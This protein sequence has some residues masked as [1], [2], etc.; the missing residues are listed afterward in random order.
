MATSDR[1]G[2]ATN[3]QPGGTY[4]LLLVKFKG[5]FPEGEISFGLYD[6]PM[7]ITGIQKVAQVFMKL[8]LTTKG[9]DPFYPQRGTTFANLASGANIIPNDSKFLSEVKDSVK[10]AIS[11]AR[12]ALNVNTTDSS[13]ALDTVEILGVDE[14]EEGLVL[15]LQLVTL[16]GEFA[17]VAVPFPE[18]GLDG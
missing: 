2:T 7:K 14:I 17:S 11:Q 16:A 3:L 9:S 1:I 6:V 18:F 15:Y 10:D 5:T 13:S 12:S 8:L 4:D